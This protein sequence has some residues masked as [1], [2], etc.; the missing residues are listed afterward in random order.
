MKIFLNASFIC[1]HLLV[2]AIKIVLIFH[3]GYV[4]AHIFQRTKR[5]NSWYLRLWFCRFRV[6]I[7]RFS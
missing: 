4:V 3:I 7:E 1:D 5:P 6:V 2:L